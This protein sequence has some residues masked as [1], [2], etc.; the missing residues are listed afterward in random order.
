MPFVSCGEMRTFTD[1]SGRHIEAEV[2]DA[3]ES[4]VTVLMKDGRKFTLS[5]EKLSE[6]DQQFVTDWRN[7]R[8][9]DAA[10]AKRAVELPAS[11]AAWCKSKVGEQVG[12]GECWTL[13][14]E[15][16]KA[17]GA[18]RPGKDL[19][20]WGRE[21]AFRTEKIQAGDVVEFRSAQFKDG[22]FTG[23]EHTAVVVATGGKRKVTIAEQNISGVK[24]VRLREMDP[25][26]L[27]SGEL[28][29]YRPQ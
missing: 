20:V 14:N 21:V 24:K 7:R 25:A 6:E 9:K 29:F 27:L 8:A 2:T 18:S 5:L 15:A 26:D 10:A 17:C 4:S 16:F 12:N 22:N 3:T 23:P 11:I 1:S 19:R 13:A 28:K